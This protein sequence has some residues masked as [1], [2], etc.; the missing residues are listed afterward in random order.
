[1]QLTNARDSIPIIKYD[2]LI[3]DTIELTVKL[4]AKF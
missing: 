2:D 1:M 3:G 4:I